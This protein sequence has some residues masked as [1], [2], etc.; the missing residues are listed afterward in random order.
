MT[1][2]VRPESPVTMSGIRTCANSIDSPRIWYKSNGRWDRRFSGI[3]R[4]GACSPLAEL[5]WPRF[6]GLLTFST[7][8]VLYSQVKDRETVYTRN[9]V[10]GWSSCIAPAGVFRNS[11]AISALPLGALRCG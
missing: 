4:S 8:G 7:Q 6:H 9:F 10:S 1:G 2:H 11:H 5:M 3:S